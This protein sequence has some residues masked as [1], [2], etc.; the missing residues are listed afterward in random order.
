MANLAQIS[1][2]EIEELRRQL[3][4]DAEKAKSECSVE[5]QT[6]IDPMKWSCYTGPA[7]KDLYESFSDEELL[8]LIRQEMN[9]LG[10]VPAQR[11]VF[12]VYRD[13]IRRRFGNWVKAL[14]AAGLREPKEKS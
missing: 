5:Q 9:L 1:C 11:E 14:R 12:C 7:G 3:R 13:Y 10:R 4:A 8:D 6:W 2:K